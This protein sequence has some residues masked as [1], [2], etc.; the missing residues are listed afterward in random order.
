[1]RTRW[2]RMNH[3]L[4]DRTQGKST[5]RFLLQRGLERRFCGGELPDILTRDRAQERELTSLNPTGMPLGMLAIAQYSRERSTRARRQVVI[6]S[7]GLSEARTTEGAF[8]DKNGMK[9]R[10]LDGTSRCTEMHAVGEDVRE[11]YGGY[12]LADDVTLVVLEYAREIEAAVLT[13]V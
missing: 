4:N 11:L 3:F 13:G 5:P 7:D 8:F 10:S 2:S 9:T 12:V 1:M 6:Y